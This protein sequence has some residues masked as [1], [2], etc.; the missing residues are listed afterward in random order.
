MESRSFGTNKNTSFQWPWQWVS[1]WANNGAHEQNEQCRARIWMNGASEQVAQYSMHR[2]LDNLTHCAFIANLRIR[3]FFSFSDATMHLYGRSCPS[4]C[5]SVHPSVHPSVR[6]SVHL[7]VLVPNYFRMTLFLRLKSWQMSSATMQWLNERRSCCIWYT[8]QYLLDLTTHLGKHSHPSI[9]SPLV[10]PSI[11]S[12][13]CPLICPFSDPSLHLS[14]LCI[15]DTEKLTKQRQR[16]TRRQQQQ[17]K[18]QQ[19]QQQ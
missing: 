3:K 19:Q 9:R 7:S 16:Q 1:K 17:Q 14:V 11:G 2:F 13:V 10:H 5:Q 18:Q 8:P 15:Y 6:P 4:T 12:S